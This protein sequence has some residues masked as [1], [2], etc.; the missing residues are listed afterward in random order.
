MAKKGAGRKQTVKRGRAS[1]S[2]KRT[3]RRI[4]RAG[5][6][7]AIVVGVVVDGGSGLPVNNA[8]VQD[9][10]GTGNFGRKAFTNIFGLYVL[11]NMVPGRNLIEA[12]KGAKVQEKD[13]TIAAPLT[14]LNFTL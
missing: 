11:P 10:G 14:I 8:R 12:S 3:V 9:V 2:P 6:L 4:A 5:G 7:N 1:K 13:K